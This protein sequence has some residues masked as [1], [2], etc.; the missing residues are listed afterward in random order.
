M[1][2]R[3]QLCIL[4]LSAVVNISLAEDEPLYVD[5][6]PVV[7]SITPKSRVQPSYDCTDKYGNFCDN[8]CSTLVVNNFS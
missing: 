8:D 5:G 2:N 6:I 1:L 4:I 3:L 7:A